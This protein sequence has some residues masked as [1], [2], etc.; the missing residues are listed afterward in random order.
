[1]GHVA[2]ASKKHV[3]DYNKNVRVALGIKYINIFELGF[4][5]GFAY[6]MV[7]DYRTFLIS[8]ITRLVI[9]SDTI[10]GCYKKMGCWCVFLQSN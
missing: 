6:I 4:A 5:Y 9:I 1:M 10:K 2:R 3:D 7:T 8:S